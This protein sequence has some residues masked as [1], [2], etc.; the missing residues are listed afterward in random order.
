MLDS[1]DRDAEEPVSGAAGLGA[2]AP[3][4]DAAEVVCGLEGGA[5]AEKP[6]GG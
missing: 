2:A 4:G 1:F 6:L 3:E 5:G